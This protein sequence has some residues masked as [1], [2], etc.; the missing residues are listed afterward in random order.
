M[1]NPHKDKKEAK[2]GKKK[3]FDRNSENLQLLRNPLGQ[4]KVSEFGNYPL[5][6]WGGDEEKDLRPKNYVWRMK[7]PCDA[8]WSDVNY[9]E[10]REDQATAK[11]GLRRAGGRD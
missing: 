6:S 10:Q 7:L 2:A 8:D 11:K 3:K 5:V 1:E 4:H 9:R